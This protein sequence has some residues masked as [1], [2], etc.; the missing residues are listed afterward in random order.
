M[1]NEAIINSKQSIDTTSNRIGY[2]LVNVNV[3]KRSTVNKNEALTHLPT[4][5]T[6]RRHSVISVVAFVVIV[7]CVFNNLTSIIQP[8]TN[9]QVINESD[10]I[11]HTSVEDH[12][13]GGAKDRRSNNGISK[14]R[15]DQSIHDL[16]EEK[17]VHHNF[18]YYSPSLH[19]LF[20]YVRAY[21]PPTPTNETTYTATGHRKDERERCH[22]YGFEYTPGRTRRRIFFGSL[23]ADDSWHTILAHAIEVK[24]LY[25]TVALVES[26]KTLSDRQE[27]TRPWRFIPNS[28]ELR[29]LQS[30]IFGWET[31]VSVD[32]YIDQPELRQGSY[33]GTGLEV[34]C[35]QR[36]LISQRWKVN[37][38][39]P[40]DIGL[41]SDIDEVFSRDFLLAVQY[42][43]VPE[44][45]KHNN[46]CHTPK[47]IAKTRV[48]EMSPECITKD[49]IW[50]H[51]DMMIGECID[52]IGNA[53]LHNE[54]LLQ[55]TI[56][57]WNG[58]G[59][60]KDGYGR[61]GPDD[62]NKMKMEL[63]RT[64]NHSNTSEPP[65]MY[66]LWKP[67]EIRIIQGGRML[68]DKPYNGFHLHNFFN[69]LEELRFK[70][71]TYGHFDRNADRK[72]L[73]NIQEDVATAVY[74][75]EETKHNPKLV[76]H[77]IGGFDAV[78]EDGKGPTPIVFQNLPQYRIARHMELKQMI[79]EDRTRHSRG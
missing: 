69:N 26:N 42:C 63:A 68:H 64:S 1:D 22:R 77:V 15:I 28:T 74:C 2:C 5:I 7:W 44:F 25:H 32:Y 34:E 72:P 31:K 37:G 29:V 4:S 14:S 70:Y 46:D 10:I 41:I 71:K 78:V 57:D 62:Y 20:N 18:T 59:H 73:V 49:R 39:T 8:V 53:T 47:I 56:R 76:K 21:N 35:Q 52:Q 54:I 45:I 55:R 16:I 6:M 30:G 50:Y 3:K 51:P 58:T 48:F 9:K 67:D 11:F 23:I 24:D 60:R 17:R 38:M 61:K 36:E 33:L 65:M 75:V 13:G 19:V 27:H 79:E 66:P 40:Y 43:D 12:K